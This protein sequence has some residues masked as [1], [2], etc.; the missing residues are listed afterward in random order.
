M[1]KFKVV[2]TIVIKIVML[3]FILFLF[4]LFVAVDTAMNL[5]DKLKE[6]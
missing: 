6:K 1:Q 2:S 5:A 4:V 3:P